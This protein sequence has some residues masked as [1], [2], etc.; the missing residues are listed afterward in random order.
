M[1]KELYLEYKRWKDDKRI[2]S[3][4]CRILCDVT[5]DQ[6]LNFYTSQVQSLRVGDIVSLKD[7]DYVP[8]DCILLKA[9]QANGQSFIQ[10]DAL[11]GERN[12]KTKYAFALT[13]ND[14]ADLLYTKNLR[15]KVPKPNPS[16]FD[17]RGGMWK[18]FADQ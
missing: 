16:L 2:N 1:G 10:T 4:P 17:F 13:Q 15:L 3:N 18:N 5:T 11:D 6:K 12:F 9:T 14:L 7:D 8:A